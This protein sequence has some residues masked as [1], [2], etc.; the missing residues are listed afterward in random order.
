MA[1]RPVLARGIIVLAVPTALKIEKRKHPYGEAGVRSS[2]DECAKKIAEGYTHPKVRAWAGECLERARRGGLKADNERS[3]AEILLKAVQSKLWM[4]DP[5]GTEWMAS[6]HLMA[7]DKSTEDEIC[8]LASDCFI[9]GTLVLAEGHRIVPVESLKPGM[10]IWGLDRWSVV[11]AAWYKGLL[12]V[13]VIALNNGSELKLTADHHVYVLDCREHPMLDDD[14]I[15]LPADRFWRGGGNGE[16][17]GGCSCH[18]EQRVEKRTRVA[19]LRE[20]MALPTPERLPFGNEE[21]DPDRAWIEGVFVADGWSY[22]NHEFSISGQDGCPKEEQK[23]QVAAICERLGIPT[24]WHRKSIAVKDPEWTLRVQQMGHHAPQKHLLSLDLGEAAAAATL[25]GVM[26]DSG[27]NTRGEGRTFTTTSRELVTQVRVL[28]KMLGVACGYRYIENHGGL[29]KNPIHR[30]GTRP[31][32]QSGRASW[33]LKVRSIEHAVFE[34]P[35]WDI[36]TDDHRVYL[37]EHD[38][39]VSQCDDLV[40]LL[41]SCFLNVGLDTMIVGHAYKDKQIEHVLCVVR[42]N[43]RW[44]YADPSTDLALGQCVKYQR[45]R[46][47]SLPNIQVLCDDRSCLTDPTAWDPDKHNFVTTGNFVGV[48]GPRRVTFAW[49]VEPSPPL[50]W[51]GGTEPVGYTGKWG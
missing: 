15:A 35:C 19:E 3:R 32:Q 37:P 12:P 33:M 7:C 39:T 50:R 11:E 46:L 44:Y 18:P 22:S 9:E 40:V 31:R 6:A 20:G 34:A 29:G 14:G 23:R 43:K 42:V 21:P 4:P 41:A 48:D 17:R 30:L 8:I 27:A 24:R 26:A 25:R 13:D 16:H 10:K 38:V 36:T 28:H 1:C 47:L 45:E 2:L 5:V 51:L 49:I